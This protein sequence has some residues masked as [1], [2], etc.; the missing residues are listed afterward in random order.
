M[1]F[2][3]IADLHG[4][5]IPRRLRVPFMDIACYGAI[6][7]EPRTQGVIAVAR[8]HYKDKRKGRLNGEDPNSVLASFVAAAAAAK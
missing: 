6:H 3:D 1:A 8:L 5:N 7:N 2:V 4:S